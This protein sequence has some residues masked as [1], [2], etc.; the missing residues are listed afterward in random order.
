MSTQTAENNN[1]KLAESM[2][3][4]AESQHSTYA[5][6]DADIAALNIAVIIPCYN[7]A[8]A[9]AT[10]VAD[11][12]KSLPTA[13]IYVYDNNSQDDTASRALAAGA[14]VRREP[15]QGKGY[16]VRR[17]FADI[18]ADLYVMVDG[19]DT[20]DASVVHQLVDKL[21]REN[22]D[23]VNGAR[24]EQEASAYRPGHKFGNRL[25]TGL[26][27]VI[28]NN[29]FNDM[30]SGYRIFSRRFVKSFPQSSGGFEIETELTIHA[31]ELQMP[32]A[33][34]GAA[35]KDRGEGSESKLNTFSDGTRI[36][37]TI[38][39]LLK[40]ERPMSTFAVICALL[41]IL[42]GVLIYPIF[43]TFFETGLVPRFP[44][45]ILATGISLL[46]FLSFTAGL[47]LD[48]V[49]RGRK[50]AKRMRY[51]EIP[52]MLSI[53]ARRNDGNA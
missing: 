41:L 39:N 1:R 25:L 36:L 37:W 15:R 9:I 21:V 12:K 30:L 45:A 11:F 29:E 51:L 3:D 48:T 22:L 4:S 6:L 14:I 38:A 24:V 53:L 46:A 8:I 43:V 50:E 13:T 17:M 42:A 5:S 28:F 31:L 19:D 40:Q 35:F 10:V 44:T 32:T 49:T 33:E 47:I 18:E 23:M 2:D 52:S 27:Q 16:V 20:Y 34:V 26:V 7:E